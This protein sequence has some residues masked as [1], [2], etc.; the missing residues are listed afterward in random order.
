[1]RLEYAL[2]VHIH[3]FTCCI[4]LQLWKGF[5][6]RRKTKKDREEEMMF[7]GM[8][9]PPL[10]MSKTAPQ[11]IAV[12]V[13]CQIFYKIICSYTSITYVMITYGRLHC[14]VNKCIVSTCYNPG[15]GPAPRHP[16][17]T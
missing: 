13:L 3:R 4:T 10:G 8:A 1:M 2:C 9:Q 14:F 17:E 7:I 11:T 16:G 12:K 15:G 5:A 6:Q